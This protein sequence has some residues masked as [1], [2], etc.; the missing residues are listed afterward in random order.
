MLKDTIEGNA[1]SNIVHSNQNILRRGLKAI[2]YSSK[3]TN[4]VLLKLDRNATRSKSTKR[5][6]IGLAC[7]R[8]TALVA[9]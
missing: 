7:A 4:K 1:I 6:R 3:S 5:I 2:L 8:N 9:T